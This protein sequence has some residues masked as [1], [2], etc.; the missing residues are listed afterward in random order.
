VLLSFET[1]ER[2]FGWIRDVDIPAGD[3]DQILESTAPTVLD[4]DR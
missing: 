3:I 1:Y 2:T 4:L